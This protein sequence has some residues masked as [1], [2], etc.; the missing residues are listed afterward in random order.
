MALALRLAADLGDELR[1][2]HGPPA[3]G[4]DVVHVRPRALVGRN[5]DYPLNGYFDRYPTVIY[6]QPP[7]PALAYMSFVSAGI[8]N[9]GITAYNEAGIF[10]A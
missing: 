7:A 9:A 2:L 1:V 4:A 6:F 3:A 10:L 8:H 5:L